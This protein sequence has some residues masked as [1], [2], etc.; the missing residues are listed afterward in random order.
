MRHGGGGRRYGMYSPKP[1]VHTARGIDRTIAVAALCILL[2]CMVMKGEE[3][4]VG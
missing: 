4:E 1:S 2:V 3:E